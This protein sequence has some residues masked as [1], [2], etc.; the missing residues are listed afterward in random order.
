MKLTKNDLIHPS[1]ALKLSGS[2]E[3]HAML[4]VDRHSNDF[5]VA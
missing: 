1:T 4:K 3:N 2:N 5:F